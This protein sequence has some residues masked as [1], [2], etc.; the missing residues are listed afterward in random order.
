MSGFPTK[1]DIRFWGMENIL[2]KKKPIH[3]PRDPRLAILS[4]PR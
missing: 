3:T 2:P 4:I 1:A